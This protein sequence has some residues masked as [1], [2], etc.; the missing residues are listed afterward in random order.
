MT[1]LVLWDSHPLALGATPQQV[2]IDGIPQLAAPHIVSKPAS[3]QKVPSTPNF[4]KEVEETLKHDGLPPLEPTQSKSGTVVFT[5][6]TSIFLREEYAV[7][8]AFVADASDALGAGVVVV[9]GGELACFGSAASACASSALAED[10]AEFVDLEGGSIAPGLVSTGSPLGLQ[11]ID[12]EASTQDGYVLDPLTEGVPEII[13][14][15]G[16]LIRAAD[17]LQFSTRD[18]LYVFYSH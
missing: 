8:E 18:A 9:R 1:D 3:F 16:A 13:G 17:G 10:D 2:W 5:N 11:E 15:S 12:Q 14:G 7:R 4:D 6:V